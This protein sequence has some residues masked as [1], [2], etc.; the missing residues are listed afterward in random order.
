MINDSLYY[1]IFYSS[2]D[3]QNCED[4][5][6]LQ[7]VDGSQNLKLDHESLPFCSNSSESSLDSFMTAD[8]LF[9]LFDELIAD[10]K[11]SNKENMATTSG[12]I[13]SS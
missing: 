3:S 11:L 13:L 7:A 8:E 2:M 12:N 5:F 10:E 6:S 1:Y 4:N 9:E